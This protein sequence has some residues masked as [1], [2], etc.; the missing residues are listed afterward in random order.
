MDLNSLE[1]GE[2]KPN[3]LSE[4]VKPYAWVIVPAIIHE[5]SDNKEHIGNLITELRSYGFNPS[6]DVIITDDTNGL[7]TVIGPESL[8]QL[9]KKS[10]NIGSFIE[11]VEAE[12]EDER[13][14]KLDEA[15]WLDEVINDLKK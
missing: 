3:D 11:K 14:A 9:K 4:F 7:P 12:Y 2:I 1:S 13:I 8:N 5:N 6:D 15:A 10:P